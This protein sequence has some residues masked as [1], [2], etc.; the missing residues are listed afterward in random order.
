MW[1]VSQSE[2]VI[3][4]FPSAANL[5]RKSFSSV[6]ISLY[7]ET[8]IRLVVSSSVISVYFGG[9]VLR[10]DESKFDNVVSLWPLLCLLL[11]F[12]TLYY[13]ARQKQILWQRKLILI[14][15][16]VGNHNKILLSW[17]IRRDLPGFNQHFAEKTD[18]VLR[19]TSQRKPLLS[20]R[21][22]QHIWSLPKSTWMLHSIT[23]N[24]FCRQ[25]KPESSC[26]EES[27]T[28]CVERKKLQHTNIKTSS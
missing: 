16:L 17:Q 1:G 27:T 11:S 3:L 28:L 14:M 22:L 21:T 5:C 18:R 13:P 4:T 2:Y 9:K 15:I 12:V 26:L 25:M 10:S 7:P 24:Y 20:K 6:F 8:N 19:R 23:G